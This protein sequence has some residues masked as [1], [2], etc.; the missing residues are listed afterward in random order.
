MTWDEARSD[1]CRTIVWET[2]GS[3]P[4]AHTSLG[5]SFTTFSF[6]IVPAPG[7]SDATR[8]PRMPAVAVQ[9][10]QQ[11][12]WQHTVVAVTDADEVVVFSLVDL[13]RHLRKVRAL[14]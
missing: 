10:M 7:M 6:Y 14:L 12:L 4:N 1:P 3:S 8:A 13:L 2:E 11:A 9:A 5:P